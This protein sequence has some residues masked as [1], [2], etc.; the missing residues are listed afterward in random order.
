M[1]DT[2]ADERPLRQIN[3]L[4]GLSEFDRELLTDRAQRRVMKKRSL[5][6]QK[7]D[8][9]NC[10]YV[11]DE[12]WVRTFTTT[13]TGK[14]ITIGLWSHGD[15]IGAPDICGGTRALSA[16]AVND[17]VLWRIGARELDDLIH[18][19]PGIARNLILALS[20]KVRWAT[21]MA[22]QL[23]TQS[24]TSRL[25]F[26]LANLAQLH[27]REEP[28]GGI[29]IEQ[30]THQDLGYMIGA[31]RQWVTRTLNELESESILQCSMRRIVVNDLNAL[32]SLVR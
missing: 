2:S 10:I 12:G 21:T 26:T 5:F 6:F 32:L 1:T 28:S 23:G 3:F 19:S 14:E 18:S 27:G 13:S 22:D 17:A 20:F 30:L 29:A 15:I 16:E 8:E 25:A 4:E 9:I 7:G 31:S 24:V 11:V